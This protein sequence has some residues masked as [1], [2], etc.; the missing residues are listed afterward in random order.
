[1]ESL[2][3][4]EHELQRMSISLNPPALTE[5]HGKVIRHYINTV[6]C[7]QTNQP[8]K[9]LATRYICIQWT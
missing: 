8:G 9:L 6:F 5:P 3:H 1:M 4:I 2:N 7:S